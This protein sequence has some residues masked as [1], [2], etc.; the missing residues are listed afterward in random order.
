VFHGSELDEIG[1]AQW[2]EPLKQQKAKVKSCH[3]EV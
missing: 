3:C 2:F 1:Q